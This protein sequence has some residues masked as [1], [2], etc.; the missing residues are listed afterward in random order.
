MFIRDHK[1]L[2]ELDIYVYIG[3]NSPL[4]LKNTKEMIAKD[5]ILKIRVQKIVQ[6]SPS[7]QWKIVKKLEIK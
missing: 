3:S 4:V 6:E 1:I 2:S 5:R 7:Q